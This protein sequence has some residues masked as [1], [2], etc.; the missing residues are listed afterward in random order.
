MCFFGE[1]T[2]LAPLNPRLQG[3]GTKQAELWETR[4]RS[5][6]PNHFTTMCNTCLGVC[7]AVSI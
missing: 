2:P 7:L 4:H 3:K 5:V 1:G 6:L